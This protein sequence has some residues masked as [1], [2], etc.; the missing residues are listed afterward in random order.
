V[1][2]LKTLHRPKYLGLE[3]LRGPYRGDEREK[4]SR[5]ETVLGFDD[6]KNAR[7]LRIRQEPLMESLINERAGLESSKEPVQ[8]ALPA[9]DEKR[10]ISG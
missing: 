1:N 2:G 7:K 10:Q 8:D 5:S 3:Q 4:S 9:S 6:E